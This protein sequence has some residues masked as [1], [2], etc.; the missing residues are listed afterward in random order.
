MMTNAAIGAAVG[1]EL[2]ETRHQLTAAIHQKDD[3]VPY[4]IKLDGSVEIMEK[5]MPEPAFRRGLVEFH[6]AA[7][8][9]RF[10]NRF[11]NDTSLIFAD[12]LKA[13]FTAV[14]D[15][16]PG[17][18][19]ATNA[20]WD[21]FRAFYALRHTAAWLRWSNV[22]KKDMDQTTFAQ[23]L[24]DNIPDIADPDGAVLVEL[25]RTLEGKMDV[26]WKSHKRAMD[27]T[28]D[29]VYTETADVTAGQDKTMKLPQ[30]L[31]LVLQPF[32]GSEK[33]PVKAKLRYK[34]T[35]GTLRLWV[36]LQRFDEIFQTAF[37]EEKR[38]IQLAVGDVDDEVT[39]D[40]I[41][42]VLTGPAPAAQVALG[43]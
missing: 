10:A 6:E 39:R 14:L 8:F 3:G 1:Q 32:E 9:T 25:V 43:A 41:I 5:L 2:I 34:L 20:Q 36:D 16:H 37:T 27:G 19:E 28:A 18:E 33:Y 21:H 31:T 15:Y 29:L 42:P 17:S 12:A 40:G 11:K 22:N 13:T 23:F 30:E 35:G 26:R 7:S 38:K 24:E 4:R